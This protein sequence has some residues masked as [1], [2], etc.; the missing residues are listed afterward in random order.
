MNSKTKAAAILAAI[1]ERKAAALLPKTASTEEAYIN[2]DQGYGPAASYY[3]A[4]LRNR[5][6]VPYNEAMFINFWKWRLLHPFTPQAQFEAVLSCMSAGP[7]LATFVKK[8]AIDFFPFFHFSSVEELQKIVTMLYNMELTVP[9]YIQQEL[10]AFLVKHNARVIEE[11]Q[12]RTNGGLTGRAG[13]V[14]MD[15]LADKAS[16]PESGT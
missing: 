5:S 9:A 12:A 1:T 7:V 4:V 14:T 10:F 3:D 13:F 2:S 11:S 16:L 6:L 8:E 15:T